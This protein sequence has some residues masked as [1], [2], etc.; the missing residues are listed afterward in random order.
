MRGWGAP[1]TS[2]EGVTDPITS[3]D[4]GWGDVAPSSWDID[5]ADYGW[6]SVHDV[7]VPS[8]VRST[9]TRLGDDGGYLIEIEGVWPRLGASARQRPTGFSVALVD[10]GATEWP[11]YSGRA[12]QGANCSTDLRA[13]VLSAY[14]PRL[15]T[16][17]YTVRVRYNNT[18]EDVGDVTIE[19][20]TRTRE[21]YA[22]KSALP[23]FFST[24]PRALDQET[25]LTAEIADTDDMSVM[26]ALLRTWGQ[27]L[28]EF[29]AL[30]VVTR[31]TSQLGVSDTS[32]T[33]EST[34]GLPPS[35]GLRIDGVLFTYS[36]VSGVTVSGLTR[37]YGQT[38]TI[39][40]GAEVSHDPHTIAD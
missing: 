21:E 37:P 6:G 40:Q 18:L 3:P 33:V 20:R 26:H 14:T 4:W 9:S 16:G 36:N 23:A 35:G 28:A 1:A 10:A 31:L 2:T 17:T 22:L 34:L 19:R 39:D 5:T 30:S 25:L 7:T 24:G 27:S 11:C 12:G 32:A 15:P 29:G 13:V 38:Q 8:F